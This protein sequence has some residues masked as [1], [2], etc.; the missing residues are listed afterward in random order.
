MIADDSPFAHKDLDFFHTHQNNSS[1]FQGCVV[2]CT[3]WRKLF[4]NESA[5]GFAAIPVQT[6]YR[7][8]KSAKDANTK[9]ER[10]QQ[11]NLTRISEVIQTLNEV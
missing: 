9:R 3:R 8:G 2:H 6:A 1:F 11:W 4:V 5:A 7:E 10:T